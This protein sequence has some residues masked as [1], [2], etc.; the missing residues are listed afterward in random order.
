MAGEKWNKNQRRGVFFLLLMIV[1]LAFLKA[2]FPL[3]EKQ[4]IFVQN[5]DFKQKIRLAQTQFQQRKDTIY[6]SNPNFLTDYK[7]Y[8]LGI[9]PEALQRLR[10]FRQEGKFVNSA[11]EFQQVTQISDSLLGVVAPYFKFPQW[12]KQKSASAKKE[13]QSA[14][15]QSVLPQKIKKDINQ[16][17]A[18]ELREV[19]GVGEVLSARIVK[20]RRRIQGFSLPEQMNEVYGLAPEVVTRIW[21][22]FEIKSAPKIE[23]INLNTASVAELQGIPYLSRTQAQALWEYRQKVGFI[24]DIN[25]ISQIKALQGADIRKIKL[26]LSAQTEK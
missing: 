12:V 2:F 5:P 15:K 26:Y 10:A 21:E 18:E 20:F 23:K 3:P 9:S 1:A 16:A 19:N 25:E 13:R 6:A 8:Q 7:A 14:E 11:K 24:K 17:T 22:R 4:N